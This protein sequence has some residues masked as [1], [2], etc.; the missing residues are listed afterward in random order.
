M[1]SC[2]TTLR[3]IL[4]LVLSSVILSL[5]SVA[6][7][8][9]QCVNNSY[10]GAAYVTVQNTG[11]T[12]NA[13]LNLNLPGGI[14]RYT[15]STSG[16]SFLQNI[17][18]VVNNFVAW[19]PGAFIQIIP[20]ATVSFNFYSAPLSTPP[21][22]SETIHF[23]FM[24]SI[25][26]LVCTYNLTVVIVEDDDGR[27]MTT[28]NGL[29][30]V[31]YAGNDFKVHAMNWDQASWKWIYSA[32]TPSSGWGTVEVAGQM[33]SF[34]DGSRIFFKDKTTKKLYNLLVNGNN[35]TLSQVMSGLPDVAGKV[36]TRNSNEVVFYGSDGKIHQLFLNGSTW[37]HQIVNTGT[38]GIHRRSISLPPG[39]SDIFFTYTG[40]S[41]HKVYQSGGGSW[42]LEQVC[43]PTGLA[44]DGYGS[45]SEL[46]AVENNA[47][48][49]DGHGDRRIHRY[50]K[51]NGVWSFDTMPISLATEA[52]VNVTGYLTKFPGEERVFYKSTTG[53]VYNIYKQGGI[54]HNWAL[55]F[56]TPGTAGDVLAAED[57]IFYINHDKWVHNF[58]W[59]GNF[60]WDDALSKTGPANTKSCVYSYFR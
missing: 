15:Y 17:Y 54:W 52:N 60:W 13:N 41:I 38:G 4:F 29:G 16:G 57:K 32:I 51:S 27:N 42:T 28:V 2:L 9:A 53:K 47:V 43:G 19:N 25:G 37:T 26:Q 10:S 30:R 33:A 48:Y 58:Y 35:W 21:C 11:G 49:Y 40:G 18:I 31:Y 56:G 24:N 55:N 59:T 12:Q 3:T 50:T 22:S 5:S 44:N 6:E 1:N 23:K 34:A 20:P 39:S 14:Y 45:N 7:V 46:L 8:R 36:A